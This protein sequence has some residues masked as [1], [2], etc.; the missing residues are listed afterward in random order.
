MH[1]D[2][3]YGMPEYLKSVDN[4]KWLDLDA[5]LN[6]MYKYP[7]PTLCMRLGWLLQKYR[8]KWYVDESHLNQLKAHR[9]EDRVF[10]VSR[11]RKS[12]ILDKTWNLMIPKTLLN[13]DEQDV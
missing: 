8:K 9:P 1:P 11:L 13:L 6:M 7:V 3:F 2:K 4:I 10:M 5:L 12:N